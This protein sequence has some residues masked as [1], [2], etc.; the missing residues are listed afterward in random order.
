MKKRWILPVILLALA[1]VVSGCAPKAAAPAQPAE[2]APSPAEKP[3]AVTVTQNETDG[4]ASSYNYS[5]DT[6]AAGGDRMIITTVDMSLV[7]DNT[8]TTVSELQ[9][10]VVAYKGY[11]SDSRRWYSGDQPYATLTLRIPA[12]SMGEALERIRAL[13]IRVDSENSS[14]QDVTEEYVD[15]SAR[16][17]NLEATE[18]ELLALLTEVRENR[19]KAEDILA[20]HRELTSIR[21]EI[22]QVKG[23][24][25][26]LER[27][28][29]MAT[30]NVEVR[31]KA[32]PT[33]VIEK[34]TW[35]PLV[36]V[37]NA[38]RALVD[39]IKVLLDVLI[40]I[41]FLSPIFLVPIA[42]I[43]LIVRLIRR[44][45]KKTPSGSNKTPEA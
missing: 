31:P 27:M 4:G 7:V 40:Y 35:N 1:L 38:L 20:I 3:Q 19:S 8:D 44:K 25:Q 23:R 39:V 33:A 9:K 6:A 29:A 12:A 34:A 32:A 28:T 21:G 45:S 5:A 2:G 11:I 43:W 17:R 37:N 16:L 30:I 41:L 14:G 18:T 13:A 22:E 15:L 24:Q 26:Y 42:V 36:T 10:L